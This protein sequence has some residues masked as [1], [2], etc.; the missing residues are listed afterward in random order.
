MFTEEL[1]IGDIIQK[2]KVSIDE[3]GLEAAAA[4]AVM[5]YGN[6]AVHIPAD[7]KVFCA[8]RPF[9][10]YVLNG[11]EAPELLFYGQINS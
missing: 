3:E 8:D 6:T 7:P 1:F 9:Q 10:F 5:M 11:N 4:T 2:S